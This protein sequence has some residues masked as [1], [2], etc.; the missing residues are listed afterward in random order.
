MKSLF[1]TKDNDGSVAVFFVALAYAVP[2]ALVMR[3]FDAEDRLSGEQMRLIGYFGLI[4]T[5]LGAA[6]AIFVRLCFKDSHL[7]LTVGLVWGGLLWFMAMG[8][9]YDLSRPDERG[10]DLDHYQQQEELQ[11]G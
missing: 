2:L 4:G 7:R 9:D 11:M 8:L 6:V 1:S 3:G 5:C 10:K